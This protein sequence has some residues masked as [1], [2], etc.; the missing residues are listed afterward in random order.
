MEPSPTAFAPRR[1]HS[2]ADHDHRRG[3][4][5]A[6]VSGGRSRPESSQVEHEHGG[7]DGHIKDAGHQREPCFLKAPEGPQGAAHPDVKTA[8]GG[9]R[10]G[11]FAH[12]QPRG[13][14]PDQGRDKENDDGELVAGILD[15]F[16]HPIGT[17]GDHEVS[18]RCQR[19]NSQLAARARSVFFISVKCNIASQR[20]CVQQRVAAGRE[21]FSRADARC[22]FQRPQTRR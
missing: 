6:S 9:H 22:F 16:L 8:L 2:Q 7:I 17:A 15:Q 4:R 14:A 21:F 1:F 20:V 18:G 5:H 13:Q 3:D 19:Q 12:H 10:G 11:Q